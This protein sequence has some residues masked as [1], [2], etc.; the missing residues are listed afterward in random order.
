MKAGTGGNGACPPLDGVI[1]SFRWVKPSANRKIMEAQELPW[2][3]NWTA[4]IDIL[5]GPTAGF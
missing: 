3:P 5:P 1:E 2:T 4:S